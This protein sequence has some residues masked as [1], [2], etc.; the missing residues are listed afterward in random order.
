M[1]TRLS[2]LALILMFVT[3]LT[4]AQQAGTALL[5]Q[6][7][8]KKT[9]GDL[10]GALDTFERVAAEF[11]TSDRKAA[12]NALLELGSI[13]ETLGQSSRARGYF[14]RVR[15]DFK[16]QTEAVAAAGNRPSVRPADAGNAASP[17]GGPSI[18]SK[19][20]FRTPYTEDIY[21]FALS[22]D[23][24][25]LVY[26]ATT[27]DGK[28][29]LWR[30]TVDPSA[31][32]EPIAGTDG[33]G[34]STKPF[35][36]PDGKSVVFFA[37]QKLLQVDLAGGVP[38]ELMETATFYGGS[39]SG[40]SILITTRNINATPDLLQ[41]GRITGAPIAPGNYSAPQF[42]D[43]RRFI[44]YERRTQSSLVAGS[45]DGP[46]TPR[47]LPA[48]NFATFTKGFLVY[49][50]SAGTL[51]AVRFDPKELSS[52]G[53][54][55]VV[56]DR[57]AIDRRAPGV[58]ALTASSGGSLAYRESTTVNRQMMWMDRN[59]QLLGTI[60]GAD[61]ASPGLPRVSPDG[62]VVLFYRQTAGGLG[63]IWAM[64]V[65][66]G[67]IRQVQD[68]A[69]VAIWSPTGDRMVLAAIRRGGNAPSVEVGLIERPA[70][71]SGSSRQIG[72]PS[73]IVMPQ[74]W[75]P[76]GA[77]LCLTGV[78]ATGTGNADL[79]VLP[80]N[81]GPMIPVAQT[82][83]SERNGRFSPDGAWIAY[84]SDEG[85]RNEI[86]VQ[87]FPGTIS[88]RQRLSLTGGV[89]PQWGRK[90]AELYFMSGDNHLMMATAA[91]GREKGTLEFSTP[92]PLFNS[93]LPQG[94][95]YD[96]VSDGDR[97]LIIATIEDPPPIIVLN[98]WIPGN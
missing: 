74:D 34:V 85:G 6:G 17:G 93:P 4:L 42:L 64:D 96:T 65:E 86:Y 62:R 77:I 61:A 16:D 56:A 70:T 45:L 72:P 54:P 60:G 39:W 90:G 94:A 68:V 66:S 58:A 13:F 82:L 7:R 59:G 26:Q 5:E 41:G 32:P 87:P 46:V 53:A 67:A 73:G 18:P 27:Q 2:I 14:D 78:G 22:P 21:G 81:N 10:Q 28:R 38:K 24:Q 47:G 51:N 33:A 44:V 55:I 37:K 35:F 97:F 88:Q 1:R 84:Q 91:P 15:N 40:D 25:T 79:S 3:G 76:N 57:V 49:A 30:Q 83:A 89:S 92:K 43:D 52:I 31:K 69:N 98:N 29:Q 95:E 71:A 50:T 75:A 63:S 8:A 12:A 48:V 80:P 19:V 11:S 20:T 9:A 23:G 36:S